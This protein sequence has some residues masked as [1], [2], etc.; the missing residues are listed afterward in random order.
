MCEQD[1]KI[2]IFMEHSG[3]TTSVTFRN[4]CW[5]E[6]SVALKSRE[7]GLYKSYI[8]ELFTEIEPIKI[9]KG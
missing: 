9:K 3:N 5:K 6:F 7:G 2:H 1:F 4:G 8:G